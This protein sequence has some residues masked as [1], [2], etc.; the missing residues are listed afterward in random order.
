MTSPVD[1]SQRHT[2]AHPCPV[3]NGYDEAARGAGVRCSGFTNGDWCRCSRE[4]SAGRLPSE[5]TDAGPVYRHYLVGDCRCGVQHGPARLTSRL[6][7]ELIHPYRDES[8]KL[9]YEVLRYPAS[10]GRDK[11]FSQRRPTGDQSDPWAWN[12]QGVRRV[13]YRLDELVKRPGDPVWISEGERDV[14]T[15]ERFGYLATC[16]TGGAGKWHLV[17]TQ[18]AIVLRGRDVTLVI[19]NDDAGRK[20]GQQVAAA[21]RGVAGRLT[22]LRPPDPHKDLSDAIRAG[23]DPTDCI[24]WDPG[25]ALVVVDRN[26]AQGTQAAE[27]PETSPQ[28]DHRPELRITTNV[29]ANVHALDEALA[30]VDPDVF[31]RAGSLVRVASTREPG[32]VAQGMPV[33]YELDQYSLMVRIAERL[34]CVRWAKPSKAA[35][36]LAAHGGPSAEGEWVTCQP[37]KDLLL[38]MLHLREWTHIRPIESIRESPLFRPDGTVMQEGGYDTGTGY[39]YRPGCSFPRVS[40]Y[41]SR[42]DAVAALTTLQHVFCDFPYDNAASAIVPIAALLTIVGRAAIQGPT[43]AFFFDASV[44]GSGKTLQ[45]DVVHAIAFG[46][47]APHVTFPERPEEQEKLLGGYAL[48]AA[49]VAFFDNVKGTLGGAALEAALTSTVVEFRLLGT[50]QVPK[51]PWSAVVMVSGN[52]VAMTDDMLRRSLLSRL[53]PQEE[54]PETR[55]GFAHANL[56]QWVLSERPRLIHA[57]LT[58]LR[59]YVVAGR[60]DQLTMQSFMEWSSLVPSAIRW[61]GG[62]SVLEARPKATS[63]GIDEAGAMGVILQHIPRILTNGAL[64]ITT[65]GLL[66]ACYPAPRRDEPPDGYDDL[67]EAIEVFSSSRSGATPDSKRLGQGMSRYV[68]RWI[69]GRRITVSVV[70]GNRKWQ[71]ETR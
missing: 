4:E 44:R 54:N 1:R 22:T 8:G 39:L 14:E 57:A 5:P 23:L 6:E 48:S 34:R 71:V 11:R 25:P 41:P 27:V 65:K 29:A 26:E 49:P 12:L 45:G 16:N 70:K 7:P 2:R 50:M 21:L 20:H 32:L 19:D 9:L 10:S 31:Q 67:R 24:P 58:L 28:G 59:A 61:A 46:R 60:P 69:Q 40:E 55:T 63:G 30:A 17:A 38:P 3:C 53:E 13:L 18:A 66:D 35:I 68:G 62:V 37:P 51:L 52:N 43:P 47:A 33:L 36:S 64:G 42:D 56:L 15:L